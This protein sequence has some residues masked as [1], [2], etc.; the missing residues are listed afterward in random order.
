MSAVPPPSVACGRACGARG[1]GVLHVR[2]PSPDGAECIARPGSLVDV[3][4]QVCRAAPCGETCVYRPGRSSGSSKG[5]EGGT[6]SAGA[7]VCCW[8]DETT[9]EALSWPSGSLGGCVAAPL[10]R[11]APSDVHA[12]PL[13][14][15]VVVGLWERETAEGGAWVRHVAAAYTVA[16][17]GGGGGVL[18]PLASAPLY[19]GVALCGR[20]L[21]MEGDGSG[22][23]RRTAAVAVDFLGRTVRL[24]VECEP[25]ACS[26]ECAR[27]AYACVSADTLVLCGDTAA[28][29]AA[30]AAEGERLPPPPSLRDHLLEGSSGLLAP[31]FCAALAGAVQGRVFGAEGEGEGGGNH[32]CAGVLLEGPS[33]VGKTFVC[34]LLRSWA[35]A[36]N[37]R[38]GG[39]AVDAVEV[40]QV[41]AASAGELFRGVRVGTEGGRGAGA[42]TVRRLFAGVQASGLVVLEGV[43]RLSLAEPMERVAV[44]Q[45]RRELERLPGRV[46]CVAT[47]AS[48]AAVAPVLVGAGALR[49]GLRMGAPA[50]PQRAEFF[51]LRGGCGGTDADAALAMAKRCP[52]T[53][54]PG[55]LAWQGEETTAEAEAAAAATTTDPAGSVAEAVAACF[56]GMVG[57]AGL[58]DVVETVLVRP[59]LAK[60]DMKASDGLITGL[61]VHGAPGSGKTEFARSLCRLLGGGGGGGLP[62]FETV[63][64]VATGVVSKVVGE[65]EENIRKVFVEARA[66]APCV[67]LIDQF[68]AIAARRGTGANVKALD[69]MLSTL[70][71][72]LDGAEEKKGA[73]VLVVACTSQKE[74]LDPAVLRSGRLDIH[75][76]TPAVELEAARRLLRD[77]LLPHAARPE[78]LR[79]AV[80]AATPRFQSYSETA[81]VVGAAKMAAMRDVVAACDNGDEMVT[82]DVTPE[83]FARALQE[84][85][86]ARR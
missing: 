4:G 60:P 22:G 2:P 47:C 10:R 30:A 72:E 52:A 21:R 66:K 11:V 50:L 59:L 12:L 61:L 25:A 27:R 77:G 54:P 81:G 56:G 63:E 76:E 44:L 75:L 20:T 45:L 71:M 3:A 40:L 9:H 38:L 35:D 32:G 34:G 58:V 48:R 8:L 46:V 13:A 67:V 28:A 73:P 68:E 80:E 16:E 18:H 29:T 84:V 42:A 78:E 15:V 5:E 37:R 64:C 74:A 24:E 26:A 17:G 79:A 57:V 36:C 49:R 33:G 65:S 43:D 31:E 55:L 85:L 23:R 70:L 14:R 39:C 7:G 51:R 6:E 62:R 41:E 86:G 1:G 19:L 83:H 82:P 53:L 69:R